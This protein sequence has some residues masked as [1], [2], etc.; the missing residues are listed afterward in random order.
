MERKVGREEGGEE[1][2]RR[3]KTMGEKRIERERKEGGRKGVSFSNN[4]LPR[5]QSKYTDLGSRECSPFCTYPSFLCAVPKTTM[6]LEG[7]RPTECATLIKKKSSSAWPERGTPMVLQGE[8]GGE[9][10]EERGER[11]EEVT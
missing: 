1:R 3:R 10:E 9:R 2:R 4:L 5:I 7:G 6:P 8:G 11:E